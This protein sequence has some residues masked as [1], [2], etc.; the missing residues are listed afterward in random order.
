MNEPRKVRWIIAHFPVK[1]FIRAA[2]KFREELNVL[3]PGQ[4]DIEIITGMGQYLQKYGNEL[5]EEFKAKLHQFSVDIPG[6]ED[7]RASIKEFAPNLTDEEIE[8]MLDTKQVKD[9]NGLKGRWQAFFE[10]MKAGAFEMSQ[11]QIN[12]IGAHLDTNMHAIDLPYLFKGHDHVA[13]ALDGEIGMELARRV[14][15]KTGIEALGYTYSGGYRIIGST[16]DITCLDDLAAQKFISFTAPSTRFFKG[17][18]I[19]AL[20]RYR[21]TAEDLGDVAENGGAIETTYIRFNGK[22]VL[23]TNHS[24]FMTSILTSENFM[25][26]LT[27]E[28]REAFVEA[29]HRVSKAERAWSIEDAEEYER[30][31]EERGVKIV[32]I[33]AEDEA[34]L[35]KASTSVYKSSTLEKLGIDPT[36]VAEIMHMGKKY[37]N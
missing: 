11:T 37:K 36:I 19:D 30:K 35:R 5:P 15:E 12:L 27:E 26:S 6:L 18:S 9:F 25:N 34:R 31:A 3:A 2:E 10:A 24:M 29:A 21:T 32:D 33:S 23:K 28:Q 7:P 20:P 22:N 16:E 1:L 4:F 14:K 17:A 13:E 8:A